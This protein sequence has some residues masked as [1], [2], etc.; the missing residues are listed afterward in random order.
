MRILFLVAMLALSAC[1]SAPGGGSVPDGDDR[2]GSVL[3]Y[4]ST[5]AAHDG[6]V[7]LSGYCASACTMWLGHEQAC[8]EPGARFGF[9]RV[10]RDFTGQ[11]QPFYEAHLPRGLR[12]WYRA[13]A[14]DSDAML[15]LSGSRI[16]RNGWAPACAT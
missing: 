14:A 16:V 7:R 2:G 15:R 11:M 6:P 8:I 10:R 1:G 5:I 4:A 13:N 3:A 9:H 12:D